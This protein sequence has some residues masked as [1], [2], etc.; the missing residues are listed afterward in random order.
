VA[1]LNEG[2]E[3]ISLKSKK[4]QKVRM[5]SC[6]IFE[7]LSFLGHEVLHLLKKAD[8]GRQNAHI[9]QVL[10][11]HLWPCGDSSESPEGHNFVGHSIMPLWESWAEVVKL[12]SQCDLENL[13]KSI[14]GKQGNGLE[15]SEE[16]TAVPSWPSFSVTLFSCPLLP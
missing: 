7:S 14:D 5:F 2:M 4:F 12:M 11:E 3:V 9:V 10:L 1:R 8:G 16:P 13:R 15:T 6:N